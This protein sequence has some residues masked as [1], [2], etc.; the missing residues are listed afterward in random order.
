MGFCKKFFDNFC[1]II[2]VIYY[3]IVINL[4]HNLLHKNKIDKFC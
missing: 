2:D 4:V 3:I 1:S